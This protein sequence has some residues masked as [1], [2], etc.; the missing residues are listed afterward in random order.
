MATS[1]LKDLIIFLEAHKL[2]I[3]LK[4]NSAFLRVN[5]RC[6]PAIQRPLIV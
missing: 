2:E 5:E 1:G 4:G 6:K 3:N